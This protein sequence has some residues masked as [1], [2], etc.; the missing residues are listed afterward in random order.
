MD[1]EEAGQ[2]VREALAAVVD[3][4]MDRPITELGFL[5]GVTIDGARVHVRLR[6]PSY[7]RAQRYGWLVVADADA[8]V[9]ALPWVDAAEVCLDDAEPQHLA[10]DRAITDLVGDLTGAGSDD[11]QQD[12][13]RLAF[14]VRHHRVLRELLDKGLRRVELCRLL[15]ADLPDTPETAVYLRRRGELG[16]PV[17][18]TAPLVVGDDGRTV[19]EEDIDD[20]LARLRAVVGGEVRDSALEWRRP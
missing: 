12:V 2:Q 20:H 16:L 15:L 5:A 7:F 18:S 9:T 11:A 1:R 6:A 14:A 17:A 13:R 4:E 10:A 19:L 8:A 3:L